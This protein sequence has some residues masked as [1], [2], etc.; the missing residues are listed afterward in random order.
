MYLYRKIKH[1]D[2]LPCLRVNIFLDVEDE[3]ATKDATFRSAFS[4]SGI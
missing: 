3:E 2:I 4:T 1:W